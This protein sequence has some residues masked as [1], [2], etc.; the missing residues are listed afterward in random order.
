MTLLR[1]VITPLVFFLDFSKAF[2]TV[3]HIILIRKLERFGIRGN[4]LRWF[5]SYL[6]NRYQYVSIGSSLSQC[7]PILTGVPQGSILG[8]LLFLLYINDMNKC[9]P[10]IDFFH[11]AD[12]TSVTCTGSNLSI[13]YDVMN[14][15]LTK[16]DKWLCCNKLSLNINKSAFMIFSNR[17][18]DNENTVY[19][20]GAALE[21]VNFIKFL[22]V[23]IDDKLSFSRHTTLVKSKI[24]KC[25]GIMYRLSNYVPDYIMKKIYS[26]LVFPYLNYCIAVWGNSSL[27]QLAR[28]QSKIN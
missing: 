17:D 15:E 1:K 14:S 27:T 18:K 24:A 8:P 21:K 22:G 7:L 19:I 11:F 4:S 2:D 13:L 3:D 20:R 25:C 10:N 9:A 6:S 16:V 26:T 23:T 12:D 5:E 28:L